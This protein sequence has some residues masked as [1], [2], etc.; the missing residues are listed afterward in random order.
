M[1]KRY[2]I[3]IDPGVQTGFAW[4]DRQ[5]KEMVEFNTA[6]FW[7]VY[8]R[9]AS[10]TAWRFECIVVIEVPN[11]KRPMYRRI[12]NN[13]DVGRIREN[14]SAKI[15]SNRREAELLADGLEQLGYEVRRVTPSRTKLN[16]EQFARRTGIKTRTS[17]HVRDAVMLV[18][19]L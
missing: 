11:S 7:E 2:A 19:G 8:H 9:F 16:A 4:Y 14:M 12:D 15:G 13:S 3:G 17:Q 5:Q 18:Y 1:K 10:E 6:N